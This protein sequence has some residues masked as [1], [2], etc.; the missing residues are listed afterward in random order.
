[1]EIAIGLVVGVL[2]GLGVG[3]VRLGARV[4]QA[5]DESRGEVEREIRGALAAVAEGRIPDSE[6]RQTLTDELA[7]S[8]EHGWTPRG[9]ERRAALIDAVGRVTRFLD[10]Q[11]RDPLA[12]AAP[13]ADAAELRERID[14]ALGALEDV[15]FF[16]RDADPET[17]GTDLV[18]LAQQVSREFAADHAVTV[19]MKLGAPAIRATVGAEPLM[20]ALYLVLHNAARFGGGTVI[21]LTVV[22]EDGHPRIR[23]RD[24]GPGFSE[25]AFKRAFD[26]FYSES[27]EGLGLGLPHARR[28]VE[29]MGGTIALRNVPDGG[30]EVE[31]TLPA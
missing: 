15:D 26:P 3:A 14:H 2:V 29:A 13:G 16:L 19:R 30:A 11:V 20:D 6:G 21:D 9:S 7:R 31:I 4:A 1:M 27:E 23:I 10:R 28:S 25:E 18:P 22:Q 24:R 5:R 8:L 17:I 12:G